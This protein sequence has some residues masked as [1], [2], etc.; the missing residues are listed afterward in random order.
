MNNYQRLAYERLALKQTE[1][2]KA[3]KNKLSNQEIVKEG[4]DAFDV[5]VSPDHCP[6]F[7]DFDSIADWMVGWS[8]AYRESCYSGFGAAWSDEERT[9]LGGE[10]DE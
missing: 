3:I 6:Y 10:D 9:V 7:G 1:Y 2:I 8:I 4:R 5:G